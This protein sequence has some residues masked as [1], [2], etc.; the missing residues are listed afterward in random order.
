MVDLVLSKEFGLNDLQKSIST[1]LILWSEFTFVD[2]IT[3]KGE[4]KVFKSNNKINSKNRIIEAT[5]TLRKTMKEDTG[6]A[7]SGY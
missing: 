5:E 7:S 6:S 4:R 2:K 1:P 3:K